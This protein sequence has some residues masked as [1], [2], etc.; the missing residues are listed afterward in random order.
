M[1]AR[2]N[3]YNQGHLFGDNKHTSKARDSSWL[4]LL[5]TVFGLL[6]LTLSRKGEEKK[7]ENNV[8]RR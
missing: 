2:T 6:G 3:E 5:P 1:K 7:E 4:E 8:S